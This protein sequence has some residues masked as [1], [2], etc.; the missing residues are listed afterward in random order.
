MS[1]FEIQIAEFRGWKAVVAIV[2]I[3]VVVIGLGRYRFSKAQK[4]LD[5][6]KEILQMEV[7]TRN[8]WSNSPLMSGADLNTMSEVQ[9][10]QHADEVVKQSRVEIT[11][12]TPRGGLFGM[13]V[14][15]VDYTVDGGPPTDGG[16]PCYFTM[17]YRSM[18]GWDRSE[19]WRVGEWR[20]KL[21][22]WGSGA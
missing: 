15:R 5:E 22:V 18:L 2:V 11:G 13:V 17:P 16:S 19:V 3:I 21:T 12:I 20:Y 6:A 1:G 14:F 9:F 4:H 8:L 7:L 10:R